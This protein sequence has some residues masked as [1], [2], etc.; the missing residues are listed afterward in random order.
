M[1]SLKTDDSSLDD[2]KMLVN[3]NVSVIKAGR[4]LSKAEHMSVEDGRLY[5]HNIMSVEDGRLYEPM[6]V[7]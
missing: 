4:S 7:D 3:L 6:S 1:L 5:E 2:F